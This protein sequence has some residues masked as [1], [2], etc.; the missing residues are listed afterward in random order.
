MRYRFSVGE[1]WNFSG[2]QGDNSISGAVLRKFDAEN[3]LFECDEE[4]SLK[5]TSG[6][7]WLL[8]T[9]Y[10]GQS[11]DDE[12]YVSLPKV[13]PHITGVDVILGPARSKKSP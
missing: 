2:P 12:P 6:R 5:G 13:R 9:R 8:T 11:F 4:V 7:Y 1:P 10:V 3:L